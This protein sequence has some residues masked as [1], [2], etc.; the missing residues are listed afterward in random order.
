VEQWNIV[1]PTLTILRVLEPIEQGIM[2]SI[3]N[4][5][6]EPI[7]RGNRRLNWLN[8]KAVLFDFADTL[9]NTERFDYDKCLR[10]IVQSLGKNGISVPF[11][12]FKR[13]YFDSRDRFYKK[14]E[15]TLEEQNF[16][17][18]I[19]ETLRSCSVY[20]SSEDERIREAAE[21]F[22]N[23]FAMSLTIDSYLPS[24]L[25][26]LHKKYKLA[27][28]SNMSFAEAIFQSLREFNI[29]NY[30]DAVIVSGILGWRKPNPK[31]F[32]KALQTLDVKAKEAAFVGDSPRA[33][34]EGARKLGMKTVL[35]IEKRKKP[36]I[37]DTAQFY[38]TEGKSNV[39]PDRTIRKLANVERAL[40]LLSK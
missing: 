11:K 35:L 26:Q 8:V 1:V 31:I 40:R 10:K 21:A 5:N 18:R 17:E 24:L 9:V 25:E 16:A 28:V 19:I 27:V 23:C 3:Y 38:S 39:K 13:G 7:S 34:I 2:L 36:P 22:C 15:K 6:S 4:G 37:T 12:S 33:D 32:K 30:F 14:T 29:V 20:V